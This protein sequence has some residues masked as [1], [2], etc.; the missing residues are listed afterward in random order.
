M[1][2]TRNKKGGREKKKDLSIL[3]D[4]IFKYNKSV[5]N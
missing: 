1:G 3:S 2:K 4:L 5:N